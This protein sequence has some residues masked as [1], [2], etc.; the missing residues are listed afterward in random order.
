LTHPDCGISSIL[1]RNTRQMPENR[2]S[3]V[4][5][6]QSGILKPPVG[7]YNVKRGFPYGKY[8]VILLQYAAS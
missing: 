8:N 1:P 4:G 6:Q 2:I 7:L 5:L 3:A